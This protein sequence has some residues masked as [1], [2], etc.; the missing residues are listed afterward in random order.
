MEKII[1]YIKENKWLFWILIISFAVTVAYAFYFQIRPVV[2]AKAYDR[3]AQNL[4]AGN[5]FVEDSGVNIKFDRAITRV[6]PLYQLILA[7]IYIIFGH[8]F[9][10]VW[11]LQA[12]LHTFSAYFVFLTAKI[13]FKDNEKK[14]KIALVAG[15]VFAFYPDLIEISA[16]LMT[17]TIYI[18]FWCMM[19]WYFFKMMGEMEMQKK[20]SVKVI[21]LG[22]VSGLAVLARPPVLFVLPAIFAYFLLR[23]KYVLTV[24]FFLTLSAVFTP[25][26]IRNYLV[27]QKVM[28]VGAA[29]A[30]NFWIG[31]HEGGKGEQEET[32]E[33]HEYLEKYGV[34]ELQ[35]ESIRQFKNFVFQHSLD[36]VRLTVWRVNK[37]FSVARPMGFWFYDSGLSQILFVLSSAAASV[38]LF[39]L[40]LY[41]AIKLWSEK[42]NTLIKYLFAFTILTPLILFI[43]VVETRYRFQI[44]PLLS[45]F[46]GYGAI[47]LFSQ[48]LWWKNK[49]FLLSLAFII[50]NAMIDLVFSLDRLQK[51]GLF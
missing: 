43:T 20:L 50:F 41:A 10:P 15:G 4:I 27:Y 45:I 21:A 7:G 18:F 47:S 19:I 32:P 9:E 34:V 48:K 6:G 22:V 38:V 23:K 2:D 31:N 14:E 8:N 46:A 26:T 36:F 42:N 3:I 13:I 51:L 17:E 12:L 40:S 29:G 30:W 1:Q 35:D 49:I 39:A 37:Y 16:M 25:W 28:P 11:I 44:Y 24:L 5:G 33:M